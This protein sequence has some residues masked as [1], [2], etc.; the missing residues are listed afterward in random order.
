MKCLACMKHKVKWLVTQ[1]E[2]IA[3]HQ[4]KQNMRKKWGENA[5]KPIFLTKQ[6]NNQ[7]GL[8]LIL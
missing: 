5:C 7:N 4:T 2:M 8:T 3:T 1:D 6:E